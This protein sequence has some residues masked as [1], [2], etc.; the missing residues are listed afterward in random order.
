MVFVNLIFKKREK[1]DEL[2][3]S[4]VLSRAFWNFSELINRKITVLRELATNFS[5]ENGPRPDPKTGVPQNV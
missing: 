1:N 4:R 5:E 2:L 3:T